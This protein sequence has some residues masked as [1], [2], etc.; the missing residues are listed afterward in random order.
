VSKENAEIARE[1]FAAYADG[2]VEAALAFLAPDAVSYAFPEWVEDP[3]YRGHDGAR[4]LDSIWRDNFDDFAIEL[5]EVRDLGGRILL[6]GEMTG[7]VKGSG[8]PIC[9]PIAALDSNFRHG[10]VGEIRYFSSW[11]Q[12]FKAATVEE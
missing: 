9:Q 5:L 10:M 4:K 1:G 2:G 11:E 7:R 6:L 3:V 12:A 8:A